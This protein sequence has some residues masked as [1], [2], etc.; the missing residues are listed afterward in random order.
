MYLGVALSSLLREHPEVIDAIEE[1]S[2]SNSELRTLLS[3]VMED[4]H[5]P[6]HVWQKIE[7]LSEGKS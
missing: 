7:A 1:D 5:I 3:W 2:K 6:Q 4:E